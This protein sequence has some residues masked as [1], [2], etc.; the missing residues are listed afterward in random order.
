MDWPAGERITLA[1]YH[2]DNRLDAWCGD[3][4][5]SPQCPPSGGCA[6]RVLARMDNV[7]DICSIYPARI[8]WGVVRQHLAYHAKTFASSTSSRSAPTADRAPGVFVTGRARSA[9]NR[10]MP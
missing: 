2:R 5:D 1:K 3:I 8:Q 6:T 9:A 4:I 7:D 10:M